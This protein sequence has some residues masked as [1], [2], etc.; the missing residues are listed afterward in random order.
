M[1][2]SWLKNVAVT[3]HSLHFFY[4]FSNEINN[5]PRSETL[6]DGSHVDGHRSSYSGLTYSCMIAKTPRGRGSRA[7]EE[8]EVSFDGRHVCYQMQYCTRWGERGV[9]SCSVTTRVGDDS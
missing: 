8:H 4:K 5:E 2:V 7:M 3:V 9:K 6:L 1:A